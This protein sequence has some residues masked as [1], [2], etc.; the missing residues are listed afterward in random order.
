M[1]KYPT[2][3]DA[4]TP[5][6]R[7][8]GNQSPAVPNRK[9]SIRPSLKPKGFSDADVARIVDQSDAYRPKA[10]TEVLKLEDQG[11]VN[12]TTLSL[13]DY[14]TDK[15]L[16]VNLHLVFNDS[17]SAAAESFLTVK[18]PGDAIGTMRV[19]GHH[20]NDE[21]SHTTG[22]IN[23]NNRQ[24]IDYKIGATGADTANCQIFILGFHEYII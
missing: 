10:R 21:K 8:I 14:V 6:I 22:I 23:T 11:N 9:Y 17:G 12:W 5:S 19:N 4:P 7:N 18:N 24:E 1:A 20:V 2:P 15:T 13:R 16:A 3:G